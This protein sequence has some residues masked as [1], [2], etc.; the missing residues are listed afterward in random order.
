MPDQTDVLGRRI[1][2]A[3]VDLLVLAVVFVI[4]A[5]LFGETD[6][7]GSSASA[8]LEGASALIFFAITLVYYGAFEAVTGRS[9]RSC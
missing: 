2:A 3:L 5:M 4:C 9:A 1:G 8:N 7:E 6:T